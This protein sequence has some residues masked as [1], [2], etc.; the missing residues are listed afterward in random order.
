MLPSNL[1]IFLYSYISK[2]IRFYL[3][4]IYNLCFYLTYMYLDSYCLFTFW[5]LLCLGQI[6]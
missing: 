6:N 3:N 1:D 4:W 5:E 2:F